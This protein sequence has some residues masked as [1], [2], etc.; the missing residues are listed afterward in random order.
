MD[1]RS[2]HKNSPI[3]HSKR[4]WTWQY[5]GFVIDFEDR[6]LNGDFTFPYEAGWGSVAPGYYMEEVPEVY[7]LQIRRRM[8]VVMD[9][10]H[11]LGPGGRPYLK[12][13]YGCDTRGLEYSQAKD[14]PRGDFEVEVA[15]LDSSYADVH[16]QTME[17]ELAADSTALQQTLYPLIGMW[18]TPVRSGKALAAVSLKS[19]ANDAI[20]F[21]QKEIDIHRVGDSLWVSDIEVR[22][23]E[24][25]PP[26]PTHVYSK[27][28][29]AY[30]AFGVCNISTG[31]G[32][33]GELEIGYMLT[34]KGTS[35]G[36]LERL[37]EFV[38]GGSESDLSGELTSL[39]SVYGLRTSGGVADEVVGIDL[40][41]L[42]AG[43][44]AVAIRAFDRLNGSVA[45][46]R[47]WIRI[48]PRLE[49]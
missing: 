27:P 32:G 2:D 14:R 8:N 30:M 21:T 1:I 7:Q 36:L 46:S 49:E 15:L 29:E 22:F 6:F 5:E 42:S 44:Y 25:G 41:S 23:R 33:M 19:T 47:T 35:P 3:P 38:S 18:R 17:V 28:G 45:L 37:S 26:N 39:W 16:R 9:A 24:E 11:L 31:E 20:G 4:R 40:S 43:D 10:L 34:R 48:Q 12:V 13:V